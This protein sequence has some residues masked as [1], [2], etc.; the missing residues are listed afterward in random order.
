M[1]KSVSAALA[2]PA[3][4]R[5]GP[6]APPSVGGASNEPGEFQTA[7]PPSRRAYSRAAQG[8]SIA[9]GGGVPFSPVITGSGVGPS[10]SKPPPA[11]AALAVKV[12]P[13]RGR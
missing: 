9:G 1:A 6:R 13:L 7:L 10:A 2:P 3:T 4:N 8:K 12:K 5:P 11:V